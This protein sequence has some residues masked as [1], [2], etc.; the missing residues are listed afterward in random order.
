MGDGW[1][2]FCMRTYVDV[3]FKARVYIGRAVAFFFYY[4]LIGLRNM[5]LWNNDLYTYHAGQ[6]G[7]KKNVG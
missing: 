2:V 6:Q 4:V 5:L 1:V 7:R 3:F